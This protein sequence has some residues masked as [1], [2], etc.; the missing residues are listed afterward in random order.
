MAT[1]FAEQALLPEGW[2]DAVRITVGADGTIAAVEPGATP[3]DAERAAGPVVPGMPNLHS[4]AFQRAMAGLA[5]RAGPEEDSFWTWREAM[6]RCV[7]TLQP[8]HVHAIAR[9]L[10]VEM[11][12]AGYTSV[13][14]FHYLHKDPAGHPYADP[15]EMAHRVGAAAEDTGI[16]LVLLPVLYRHGGFGGQSPGEGQ[17]RF[18]LTPDAYLDLL[19]AVAPHVATGIAFHSLRAV[20]GDDMAAVLAGVDPARPVHIHVAEQRRE[21]EDC[22]AWSGATPIDWLF[23]HVEVT[24]RWCLV[25]ATHAGEGELAR[26]AA[27][28]AVAGLCPTTEANLG[29]GMFPARRFVELGGRFGVG[30]DSHVTVSPSDELRWLEY[31]RRLI[32]ERRNRLFSPTRPSVGGFL[33]DAALAGGAAALGLP[34]GRIAAGSRADLVVLDG[35]H[36]LLAGRRGDA[37]LDRWLFAGD[38]RMVRDVMAGGVWRVRDGRHAGEEAAARGF[39]EAMRALAA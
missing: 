32:E 27:S 34:A 26:M 39:V 11:L 6:Y 28:G 18:T 9:Q 7:A 8:E 10:Y 21:V 15:A 14:E 5:E 37:V 38:A 31:G 30:S 22:R 29:D 20:S 36:P 1:I 24:A 23:D 35:A 13:A 33:W 3:Q 25:H 12:K 17:R 4:H 2:A 19:D 16:G